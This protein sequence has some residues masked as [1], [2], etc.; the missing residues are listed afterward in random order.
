MSPEPFV[1]RAKASPAKRSDKGYRDENE[2]DQE[3]SLET[4]KNKRLKRG[5]LF[6]IQNSLVFSGLMFSPYITRCVIW[7]GR[8]RAWATCSNNFFKALSLAFPG[9]IVDVRNYVKGDVV[10]NN[11]SID[12]IPSLYP[13][14]GQRDMLARFPPI[15]LCFNYES[16]FVK[17]GRTVL[18]CYTVQTL[19]CTPSLADKVRPG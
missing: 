3:T 16:M 6:F 8:Y 15:P 2:I 4:N 9:F 11:S 17:N 1:S 12:S 10:P 18:I 14:N 13:G 7:Y 19:T 5:K